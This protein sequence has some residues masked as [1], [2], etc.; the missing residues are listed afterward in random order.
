M[1]SYPARNQR[2]RP[3]T[4]ARI[5]TA[6][7]ATPHTRIVAQL[8]KSPRFDGSCGRGI[9]HQE[10]YG[11]ASA[12]LLTATSDCSTIGSRPACVTPGVIMSIQLGHP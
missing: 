11:A 2:M 12:A 1:N 8:R 5:T 9:D 4:N 10:R 6:A 3:I 7:I